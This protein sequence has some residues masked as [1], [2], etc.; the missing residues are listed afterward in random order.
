[1]KNGKLSPI[2]VILAVGLIFVIILSSNIFKTLEPGEKGVIF[3][4]FTTG[5][6]KTHVFNE[7]FHLIAPWNTMY[8]YNV[9]EQKIEEEMS[10]LDK[11]GLSL[12]VEISVRFNPKYER[13]GWLHEKFGP[14]Y[15]AG[16]VGPEVRSSVRSV[17][18]RFTAEEIYAT[19]RQK[20]ENTIIQE[21]KNILGSE[22]N[23]IDMRAL[24]IRSIILPTK[25]KESIET[26]LEKE[27][28]AI[29][30]QFELQKA[31][32]QARKDSIEAAG[33]A[34]AN[35]I[36][37]SSLTPELLRMRGIEATLKLSQSENSK[38]VIIG[39]GKD[40]MPLILGNN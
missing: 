14:N 13:I 20:V 11:N 24:L 36:I 18:G 30:M 1:M 4:K 8:I 37:N 10:V 2:I 21:T 6:D 26:K 34:R 23:N 28:Q 15:I 27:Q 29:A 31:V 3:R 38:T 33:K 5:L 35:K 17:M 39:S 25:I 9:R 22:S 32:Q 7:G 12:R 16:L 19:K 40:G